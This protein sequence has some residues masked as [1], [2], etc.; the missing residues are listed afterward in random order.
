M[1]EQ[2]ESPGNPTWSSGI[3]VD[4]MGVV[5]AI[6][7]AGHFCWPSFAGSGRV[8]FRTAPSCDLGGLERTSSWLTSNRLRCGVR[9]HSG[10]VARVR[11]HHEGSV[12]ARLRRLPRPTKRCP[13]SSLGTPEGIRTPD[14]WIR[15]PLLYPVELRARVGVKYL[16]VSRNPTGILHSA[17]GERQSLGFPWVSRLLDGRGPVA[18]PVL[19][20]LPRRDWHGMAVGR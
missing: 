12:A 18:G 10:A 9:S 14:R 3:H 17:V 13:P 7:S 1:A 2:N 4:S 8:H 16:K 19:G 5:D 15:N 20:R 11:A 6:P